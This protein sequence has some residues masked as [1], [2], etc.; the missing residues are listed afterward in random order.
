VDG[1][2]YGIV[3]V[4][5]GSCGCRGRRQI[6]GSERSRVITEYQLV[7]QRRRPTLFVDPRDR[8]VVRIQ[9]TMKNGSPLDLGVTHRWGSAIWMP[10]QQR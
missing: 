1:E 7:D 6:D 10:A 8:P 4:G 2:A 9:A 5:I 3:G